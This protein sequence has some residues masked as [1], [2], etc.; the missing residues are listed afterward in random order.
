MSTLLRRRISFFTK[1]TSFANRVLQP[2]FRAYRSLPNRRYEVDPQVIRQALRI[3]K[4]G[5]CLGIFP[6]G[7]R[8]WD[9]RLLPFKYNT[10]KFLLSVQIPIVIV[11]IKGAFN[12]LPRW[13]HR[14]NQ[15]KIEIEVQRCFSLIPKRWQIEELKKELELY[16]KEI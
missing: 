9:G 14:L 12:V 16:F 4:R 7:E 8:T 15:G 10:I 11:T 1:S 3:I 2:I 13:S 6:E 5:N